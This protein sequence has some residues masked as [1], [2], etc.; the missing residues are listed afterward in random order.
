MKE[1]LKQ[2]KFLWFQMPSRYKRHYVIYALISIVHAAVFLILPFIFKLILDAFVKGKFSTS[3][4]FIYISITILGYLSIRL[5]SLSN[6]H[7]REG[8]RK[9][10]EDNLFQS[11]IK[12][13]P[14]NFKTKNS[15]YWASIFS[16]DTVMTTQ[17]FS[18]F[19]YTLPEEGITLFTVLVVLWIY[20]SQIFILISVC[21]SMV[22]FLGVL[23][24][25]NV[26][27]KYDKSQ[28]NLRDMNEKANIY[29]KG[30]EDIKHNMAEN[31]FLAAVKNEM[32]KYSQNLFDYLKEDFVITYITSSISELIKIG[33]V[34]LSLLYFLKGEYTFGTAI[35]LIQFSAI[36]YDKT[37]YLFENVKW[38]QNFPPHIKKVE[39]IVKSP[40][41]EV[42]KI[43]SR[44][45][46]NLKLEKIWIEYNGKWIIKDFSMDLKADEKV[47][48][49]GKSGIGK[50]T[51]LK[52]ISGQ[53]SPKRG[54]ITFSPGRPMIGVLSQNPYLFN[55]TIKEN[56]II[57][58]PSITEEDMMKALETCGLSELIKLLPMGL[59]TP[60]G[61]AG[62]LISGGEKARL[63]LTRLVILNP[64]LV[65]MDEPLTGVDE[66]QKDKVLKYFRD[67]LNYK[68][69]VIVTHDMKIVEELS[70]RQIKL[71]EV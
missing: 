65:L 34:G 24:D 26:V 70:T 16:K 45:F 29:L 14:E 69:C 5:W 1:F 51:I 15:G 40:S 13:E 18:D 58:N 21:L 7:T 46:Q 53:L 30:V 57:S 63:A 28:E 62:K 35:L 67:F 36:A 64:E 71:E 17:M 11:S 8:M 61:Q 25:K 3:N 33:S 31:V 10:L 54:R 59:N 44:T 39:M 42:P 6:I 68:T 50:S 32:K 60:I 27:P 12:M 2:L 20:C 66:E 37:N 47:A 4:I 41:I 9:I 56:L 19:V 55:R 48:I 43:E 23:R 38:L 52:T 49:L 22:I